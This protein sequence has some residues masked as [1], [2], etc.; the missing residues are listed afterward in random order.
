[1]L[2][3]Q[4]TAARAL[5]TR[6][7]SAATLRDAK[8]VLNV[9]A[10]SLVAQQMRDLEEFV[11]SGGKLVNPP[12]G[13]HFPKLAPDQVRPT[14][15]QMDGM[16][17]IWETTYFATVRKN[18]GARTFN[19]ASMIFDVRERPDGKSVLVHLLNFTDYPSEDIA[20]QVLGTWRKARLYSIDAPP[21]D[22]PVYAVKDGTG[23]DVDRIALLGTVVME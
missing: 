13:W 18:F 17:P 9:D 19:T 1:M 6:R 14:R 16:Q 15:K 4:H 3:V 22:L 7:L 23:V 10:E 5:P 21:R 2:A 8:V 11:A 12:A 20:V